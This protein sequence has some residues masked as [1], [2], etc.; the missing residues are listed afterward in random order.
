MT[1]GQL[2]LPKE[3]GESQSPSTKT[4]APASAHEMI[5]ILQTV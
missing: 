4:R 3:N 5:L 1:L 2:D